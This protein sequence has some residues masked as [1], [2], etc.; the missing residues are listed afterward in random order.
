MQSIPQQIPVP[1]TLDVEAVERKLAELWEQTA[2]KNQSDEETVLRARVA[3]L[4]VFINN[5]S[6]LPETHQIISE[7][8]AYHP[9]RALVMVGNRKAA[10]H[11]IV[12]YAS[13]FCPIQRRSESRRICCEEVTFIAG[14]PFVS[15]LPSASIPLLVPDLSVFLWWRDALQTQDKIF[16]QLSLAAGRVVID[17]A[18]FQNPSS[19]FVALG[20]FFERSDDE[21]MAIS[22][23]NWA[24]LT[25]WRA[26]L[27]NFYDVPDYRAELDQIVHVRID[28][29]AQHQNAPA[30]ASQAILLAGW[31]ASRLGWELKE[32]PAW[33]GNPG[34]SFEFAKNGRLIKLQLNEVLRPAMKA[35]RL[36]QISLETSDARSVFLVRRSEDGLHLETQARI[37]ERVCPDRVLPVRNRTTAALLG[38]EMEILCRDEVYEE[39]VNFGIKLLNRL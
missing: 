30:P 34:L 23:I 10:A 4:M 2:G 39:A 19:E 37:G 21:A 5:E 18:D 16:K 27:A 15:E 17:S 26:L 35:G 13:A 29:V 22:D 32:T 31:L 28:F 7:L 38:R 20:E 36:A 8:A 3:D 14:G 24:R 11:D 25:S 1:K 9:C 12:M 6:V 33:S